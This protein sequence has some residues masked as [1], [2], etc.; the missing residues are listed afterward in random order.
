MLTFSFSSS[1]IFKGALPPA[2]LAM[3]LMEASKGSDCWDSIKPLTA[4][5][6]VTFRGNANPAI[7]HK[8]KLSLRSSMPH[9][10]DHRQATHIRGGT[11]LEKEE[12]RVYRMPLEN[13]IWWSISQRETPT[14]G[15]SVWFVM[16][17]YIPLTINT[18]RPLLLVLSS[19]EK[20]AAGFKRI[21][22]GFC[23]KL[24]SFG[25]MRCNGLINKENR[26]S[27]DRTYKG[28]RPIFKPAKRFIRS[29][30]SKGNLKSAE[31]KEMEIQAKRNI[32]WEGC[33]ADHPPL[34][35]I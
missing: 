10:N 7:C 26:L 15:I 34:T 31:Q 16:P 6:C 28:R 23:K 29:S 18:L 33:R 1:F 35:P 12:C 13:K 21:S 19:G 22:F 30:M 17:A 32:R 24:H 25:H 5:Y 9:A 3:C 14:C 4:E 27:R 11:A 20:T 8:S 2:S